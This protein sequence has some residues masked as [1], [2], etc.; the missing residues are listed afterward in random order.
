MVLLSH[1]GQVYFD[2]SLLLDEWQVFNSV[3]KKAEE[4]QSAV[5]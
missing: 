2:I 4:E 5:L 3:A 1:K